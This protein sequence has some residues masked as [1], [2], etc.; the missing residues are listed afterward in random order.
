MNQEPLLKNVFTEFLPADPLAENHVRTVERACYSLVDT[1]V[2][3]L[4]SLIHY[5]P[6]VANMLGFDSDFIHHSNFIDFFSGKKKLP[7][8]KYY[9]MCYGG[10][11]F[12]SW[13]G[14]LGDGRAINLGERLTHDTQYTLQLKGAGR[15]PYSRQGDGLA[16]LRSSIRE[17]LCSEAMHALGVPTSRALAVLTSGQQVLRDMMYD[18]NAALEPGAIVC[19]VAPSFIRFGNF[20]I[21][22]ARKEHDILQRLFDYTHQHFFSHIKNKGKEAVIALYDEVVERTIEMIVH[23]MRVGFVHG[24]M[25][26]DNMS[27]HGITIDY[28]PYGWLDNF[29]TEWTPNTTDRH[30]RRYRYGNQPEIGLWNSVQLANALY[31]LVAE[32][33]PFEDILHSFQARYE[34][35]YY[36]MMRS[37]LG[38]L[39]SKP[40]DEELIR[41]LIVLLQEAETD[42]TIFFRQLKNYTRDYA[43][44]NT[45]NDLD[46]IKASFYKQD[47]INEHLLSKWYPWL[48]RYTLRLTEEKA[49]EQE[50]R[51]LMDSVNP[52]YVLRNYMAQ[53][54]IDKASTGDFSLIQELYA[55]LLHPYN[56]QVNSESWY[57]KRPDWAKEKVGCSM[58]SCSS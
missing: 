55:L 57:C 52:K 21:H 50:R 8:A 14:Q 46:W 45:L 33:K 3:P 12:G 28:G 42:M 29:D 30:T 9:A 34:A 4:P 39:E 5:S 49:T 6:E 11:Q 24:V 7:D 25:N 15:T 47:E 23:W 38:L 43:F 54:A 35:R 40:E 51:T 48:N 10:H 22:A 19:R 32:A 56:E 13:A 36:A 17:Y 20:Q 44:E 31:P 16:V 27:I 53:M 2:P 41:Q 1:T 58:L 26:T 18:G 37:K